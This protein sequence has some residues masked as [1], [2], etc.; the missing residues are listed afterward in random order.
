MWR[1][2]MK[3][4]IWELSLLIGITG[5][6]FMCSLIVIRLLNFDEAPNILGYVINIPGFLSVLS[7]ILVTN[8]LVCK[9]NNPIEK[10]FLER[11]IGY[12]E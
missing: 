1:W 4:F 11:L 10:N 7:A 6:I 2:K 3:K 9:L 5:T 8:W 12:F